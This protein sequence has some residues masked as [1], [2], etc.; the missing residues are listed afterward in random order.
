M[1][2]KKPFFSHMLDNM[3][4]KSKE[5]SQ[6]IQSKLKKKLTGNTE[7]KKTES[8]SNQEA[9]KQWQYLLGVS[10][11]LSL[12]D[13]ISNSSQKENLIHVFAK[14]RKY[15]NLPLDFYFIYQSSEED[16]DGT[17][18]YDD[19]NGFYYSIEYLEAVLLNS[20]EALAV[21]Q[22][23]LHNDQAELNY[24]MYQQLEEDVSFIERV[25][26][27]QEAILESRKTLANKP[28]SVTKFAGPYIKGIINLYFVDRN[29]PNS[30]LVIKDIEDML[31]GENIVIP[32]ELFPKVE[33]L[34][35]TSIGFD[36]WDEKFLKIREIL[37]ELKAHKL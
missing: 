31:N 34:L 8:T 30:V 35:T 27:R 1:P 21:L 7:P 36:P 3:L 33:E 25:I 9:L 23:M 32:P 20:R 12:L 18:N 24:S 4:K 26:S 10:P 5:L 28:L 11:K 29:M 13:S 14:Q 37:L 19:N 22:D 6:D 17:L 16:I 2:E 15:P